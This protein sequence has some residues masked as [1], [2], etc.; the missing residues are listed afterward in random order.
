MPGE[1]SSP[2]YAPPPSAPPPYEAPPGGGGYPPGGYP[3]QGGYAGAPVAGFANSEDK[4]WALVAHFGGAAGMFLGAG[5][6]GWVAPL[7]A[8]LARGNQSPVVRQHAVNALNFQI[9]W[10]IIGVVGWVLV[11]VLIGFVVWLAAM[12]I[13]I[14]FGVIAGLRAN[15]GQLYQYPMSVSMIK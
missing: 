6:G 11:C 12:V 15:E 9:L 1:A 14:V 2:G 10:S 7:V 3:P 5:C 13:G 4:T 8:L